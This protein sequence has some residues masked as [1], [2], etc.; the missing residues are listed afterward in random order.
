MHIIESQ[1]SLEL[2]R[3]HQQAELKVNIDPKLH[4]LSTLDLHV[5]PPGDGPFSPE[6]RK[7]DTDLHYANTKLKA[8][9]P[10]TVM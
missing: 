9:A 8:E 3:K 1:I 4:S 5:S 10:F 2:E 7:A 6:E